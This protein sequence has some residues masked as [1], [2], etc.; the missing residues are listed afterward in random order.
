M[1][2]LKVVLVLT[3]VAV[4]SA[5][6]LSTADLLSREKIKQN[7][8]KA[9]NESIK[10]IMPKSQKVVKEKQIYKIY[11]NKDGLLGYIFIA[12]GQG[13]QSKIEIICG[14]TPD[15]NTI[16]GIE[17][18]SSKETPGLGSNITKGWFKD[19]FNGLKALPEITYTKEEPEKDNQIKAITGATVSSRAVVNI[20]NRKIE[21]LREN[22]EK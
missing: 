20:L 10:N 14:V 8:E 11:N 15:F 12:E 5:A 4:F 1:K 21:S 7:R 18:L 9:I 3:L 13:Y 22:L 2:Y 19:Q 6:I 16:K 17:I